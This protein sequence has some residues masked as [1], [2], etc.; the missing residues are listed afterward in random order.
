MATVVAGDF[1]WDGDKD[2]SNQQKHGVGFAEAATVF[3]DPMALY[4]DD[5]SGTERMVVIGTSLRER[6]L[7]I[8]HVQ[9]GVRDRIISARK[10]G[11]AEREA[12]ENG[13]R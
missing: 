5:G 3:A 2:Q 9:R 4:L 10:A 1:E 7:F 13:G 8:V 6:L 11:P 12:Y